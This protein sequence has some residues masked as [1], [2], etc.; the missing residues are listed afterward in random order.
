MTTRTQR[1][2]RTDRQLLV[3][4][5]L[6]SPQV[7]QVPLLERV[8]VLFELLKARVMTMSPQASDSFAP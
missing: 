8:V 1:N 2:T 6:G 4:A 7:I 5:E 3:R